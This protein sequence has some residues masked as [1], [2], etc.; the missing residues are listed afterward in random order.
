MVNSKLPKMIFGAEGER[1]RQMR[2]LK[3]K[4]YA[5]DL[6]KQIEEK[7]SFESKSQ[8]SYLTTSN[9][10]DIYKS[11]SRL[12]QILKN[13][14]A[15]NKS[16]PSSSRKTPKIS[17]INQTVT[18]NDSPSFP[19]S[20]PLAAL[21]LTV[22][23]YSPEPVP[24]LPRPVHSSTIDIQS[25]NERIRDLQK[26][27]T[28]QQ[29]LL[30][31]NS[32]IFHRII[33]VGYPSI[34]KS[35]KEI[36]MMIDRIITS[37]LNSSLKPVYDLIAKNRG[38]LDNEGR[39]IKMLV[40]DLKE[41]I[42]EVSKE[43][44]IFT[45]TFNDL[46]DYAQ[47]GCSDVKV[48]S[49]RMID[50]GEQHLNQ[51]A[52]VQGT[53]IKI[54]D[55]IIAKKNEL[56]AI[57]NE[58]ASSFSNFQSS[59]NDLFSSISSKIAQEIKVESDAR[60]QA[61]S[62]AQSQASEVNQNAADSIIK[63]QTAVSTLTSSF[64]ESVSSLSNSINDAFNATQD[65]VDQRISE[66]GDQFDS[67][68]ES[69]EDNFS[70]IQNETVSTISTLKKIVTQTRNVI[71]KVVNNESQTRKKNF[72]EIKNKYNSFEELIKKEQTLQ[73]KRIEELNQELIKNGFE[74]LNQVI[75][76]PKN[77]VNEIHHYITTIDKAETKLNA[78]ENDFNKASNQV[79]ESLKILEA[80]L[81]DMQ[82]RYIN[83]K[84]R[85]EDHFDELENYSD[86]T[87]ESFHSSFN[88]IQ[89]KDLINFETACIEHFDESITNIES[90]LSIAIQQI[91]QFE[92]TKNS[93]QKSNRRS[94]SGV[95]ALKKL[96]EEQ[97][98]FQT[99]SQS[100]ETKDTCT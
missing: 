86:T 65:E 88:L 82:T 55:G 60:E 8:L 35:T 49:G 84:N 62:I 32:E 63:L 74:I 58:T 38:L 31:D 95:L 93:S 73:M 53:H 91:A 59:I 24:S 44:P 92:I 11:P 99:N 26:I 89:R 34:D 12:A 100:Q 42:G 13:N 7:K 45:T 85:I 3:A 19:L 54:F 96:V 80:N 48:N 46:A 47:L 6:R 40:E 83:E 9:D 66:I 23:S 52:K 97:D 70:A 20:S 5:E 77:I 90:Q 78:L 29:E 37:D 18:I 71:E 79:K 57:D 21:N 10:I 41:T 51:V 56:E 15:L 22:P 14:K 94:N 4:Q 64:N 30:D 28:E 16:K 67:F 75:H 17:E 68:L 76:E 69:A 27:I 2:Q 81:N 98:F 87:K 61:I 25:F 39:R 36:Q 1:L 43:V 50:Q 72:E 33:D